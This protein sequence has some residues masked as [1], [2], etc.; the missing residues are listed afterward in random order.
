MNELQ[1]VQ[2]SHEIELPRHTQEL[3]AVIYE[4]GTAPNT[5][6]AHK[7]DLE[8]FW[9]WAKLALGIE[10]SYPVGVNVIIRYITDFLGGIHPDVDRQLVETGVKKPGPHKLNTIKRRIYTLSAYHNEMGYKPNPCRDRQI[11][12]LIMKAHRALVNQGVVKNKKDAATADII[13]RLLSSCTSDNLKDVRDK[14]LFLVGFSSGGRRRSELVRMRV[15]DLRVVPGGYTIKMY[16]SKSD[17]DGR[18]K[19]FPIKKSS[20]EALKDWLDKSGIKSG[21]LFRSIGRYD[22]VGDGLCE[23]AVNFIFK[24][25]AKLANLDLE[26]F[27]AHSLRSGFVTEAASR[28]IPIWEIMHL[29]NHKNSRSVD[30]YY[31]SGS[32]LTNPAADLI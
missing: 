4:Q 1:K 8:K 12:N 18:H 7:R 20:A 2:G 27:S 9:I 25:R 32:I 28:G 17:Y 31:R 3:L 23:K 16:F 24:E 26:K 10:E 21:P 14:A 22:T 11:V 13:E 6:K 5:L 30:D 19:E 29:T 15:E